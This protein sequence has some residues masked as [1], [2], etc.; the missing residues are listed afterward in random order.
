MNNTISKVALVTENL[1]L[2]LADSWSYISTP[3]MPLTSSTDEVA[4]N[5]VCS[6]CGADQ[7]DQNF[8][9]MWRDKIDE[10]ARQMITVS[11]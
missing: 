9:Q 8:G 3:S 1:F 11:F 5:G 4:V 7:C 6:A 2:R 10:I